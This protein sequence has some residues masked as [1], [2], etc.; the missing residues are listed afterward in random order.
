MKPIR[1]SAK[2]VI[3]QDQQI[4]LTKN[5][6]HLGEFYLFPGGGQE[7]GETLTQAVAR[8]CQEEIGRAVEV[9]DLLH[10]REYIGANHEFAQADGDVHQVEFYF[11]CHL[12]DEGDQFQGHNPDEMQT[13]VEWIALSDLD[14]IRIYPHSLV[15]PLSQGNALEKIC[16]VGD[17]N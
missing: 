12:A 13:G 5:V 11:A 1:N 9:G 3:I 16:Y 2:A 8:E 15:K 7:K 10:L 14:Q 4:L 6:D 17:T